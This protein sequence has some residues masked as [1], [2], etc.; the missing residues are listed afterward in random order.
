MELS[1]YACARTGARAQ[2][3]AAFRRAGQHELAAEMEAGVHHLRAASEEAG[4]GA[5]ESGACA[6]G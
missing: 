6:R 5:I 3:A 2:A 1:G 4:T